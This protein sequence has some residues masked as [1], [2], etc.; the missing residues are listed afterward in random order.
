MPILGRKPA[1]EQ[2]VTSES[3]NG[4]FTM[5]WIKDLTHKN[6]SLS[7]K[8]HDGGVTNT[9][10]KGKKI[11]AAEG[12]QS[13]NFS[14]KQIKAATKDFKPANK[15]GEGGFGSVYKGKLPD[16]RAISVKVISPN[17]MRGEKEFLSEINTISR[18]PN[19]VELF[20][21]CVATDNKFV[22]VY[23][24]L[25]NGSLDNALFRNKNLKKRLNWEIRVKICIDI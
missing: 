13:G 12:I 17:S 10:T 11:T 21:H 5:R 1:P 23:Q 2:E 19:I 14:Y 15:N 3:S 20:G 7:I 9:K 16:G 18:H 4:R 8:D 6:F 25:A 24:Y 22:S